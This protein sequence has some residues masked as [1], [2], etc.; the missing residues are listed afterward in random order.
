MAG[1]KPFPWWRLVIYDS[2]LWVLN[3]T[4]DCFFREIRSRGAFKIPSTGP[5]IFVGAPHANQFV[6]PVILMNLVKKVSGR[7][8]SFL[9]AAKSYRL[10]IIGM[11]SKCQLSIPVE[12]P[13]DNLA[14][15]KGKI[16]VD[17]EKDAC[18]I[19]GR[20]TSFTEYL[21]PKCLLALPKSLGASEVLEIIDD[22]HVIIRKPFKNTEKIV[23]MLKDGSD[24]KYARKVDQNEVYQQVFGHLAHGNCIGIFPEGGSHD[25]TDLLPIKA[26]VAIMALGAMAAYPDC[27]VKIVPCGMNYFN[28]H[29]FRSRAV[30][31]YG[32]PIEISK[33]LIQRY[34]D[35]QTNREAVKELLDVITDG[36]R[37]VTVTCDSFDTLMVVQAARRLYANHFAARLPLPLVIE[38]NRRLVLGYKTYENEPRVQKMKARIFEYNTRLDQIHLPDHLLENFNEK[39]KF[40]SLGILSYRFTKLVLLFVLALPGAILFSPVFLIA[41]IISKKKQEAALANSVVKIKGNDVVATWKI[42]VSLVIAPIFYSFYA[43]VGAFVTRNYFDFNFG[44][45]KLWIGL[46]CFN[47]L[48]TYS[49]LLTG[50]QGLDTFKSLRPLYISLIDG[51]SI[52]EL[53]QFRSEL[54]DEI[55]EIVDEFGWKL[56]PQDFNLLEMNDEEEDQLT[57]TMKNRRKLKK[58]ASS[59]SSTSLSSQFSSS[60]SISDGV[61]L[62]NSEHSLT[63]IPMFSDY[64]LHENQNATLTPNVDSDDYAIS[65]ASSHLELNFGHKRTNSDMH[66]KL[67]DKI[68]LKM[69]EKWEEKEKLE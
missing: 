22:T 23:K 10:K 34:K 55:T 47:V 5:V 63:N 59:D 2:L 30:I 18:L 66:Q 13:Q 65:R 31:E 48:I 19:T 58:E 37:A 54:T 21:T 45:I 57:V 8:V 69:R 49:A 25:R 39:S 46:Y 35:P 56:F 12:R 1:Y 36:L 6:D 50:E 33:E 53:K 20:N 7:R 38:M 60:S 28:A 51:S 24:F 11:M 68:K 15:G 29:K 27:D 64:Q 3:V 32:N 40:R 52:K 44:T 16:F 26:G 14:P 43:T 42:L 61:S 4:F 41:K 17:F 9:I 67:T 62:L